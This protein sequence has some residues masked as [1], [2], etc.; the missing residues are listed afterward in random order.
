MWC[1][2]SYIYEVVSIQTSLQSGPPRCQSGPPLSYNLHLIQD[3][4]LSL[5]L[6]VAE[7]KELAVLLDFL[8]A[9]SPHLH[10]FNVYLRCTILIFA[11]GANP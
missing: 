4:Q 9:A 5:N 7:C 1:S 11:L 3:S 2:F 8:S 10:N 6:T